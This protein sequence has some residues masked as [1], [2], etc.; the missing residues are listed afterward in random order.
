MFSILSA[1]NRDPS[2]DTQGIRTQ[3]ADLLSQYA[4]S[5]PLSEPNLRILF[6]G[7]RLLVSQ[8]SAMTESIRDDIVSI[9]QSTLSQTNITDSTLRV[10]VA[11]ESAS[12]QRA[13]TS[14][15]YA[16]KDFIIICSPASNSTGVKLTLPQPLFLYDVV[17]RLSVL[18]SQTALL[19]E[20]GSSVTI[21]SLSVN[22]IL[23]SSV[24]LPQGVRFSLSSDGSLLST[25]EI[26]GADGTSSTISTVIWQNGTFPVTTT[27]SNRTSIGSSTITISIGATSGHQFSISANMTGSLAVAPP[28]AT[29]STPT[30][31][32]VYDPVQ[33]KWVSTGCVLTI[34]SSPEGPIFQCSCPGL[35]ST[36]LSSSTASGP[37]G[38]DTRSLT[39][40]FSIP[41]GTSG[42]YAPSESGG[43]VLSPSGEPTNI[44]FG[45][46]GGGST[47]ATDVS[48]N[49][50]AIIAGAVVAFVVVAAIIIGIVVYRQ[51]FIK[52]R[53]HGAMQMQRI[54]SSTTRTSTT[55][56]E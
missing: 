6:S 10:L 27:D 38:G 4:I 5:Q 36:S 17:R 24:Q 2:A 40:L 9:L 7:I 22:S 31:C 29:S 28:G 47:G 21:D 53:R 51:V 16:M 15:L 42:G 46:N 8:P 13:V 3:I 30:G 1:L 33:A 49:A 48:N 43:G 54:R 20:Q 34:L 18:Q 45:A 35:I 11:V 50:I 56:P 39:L 25:T 12:S 55:T 37:T 19:G 26:S 41:E 14:L 52:R 44:P 32:G 23:V